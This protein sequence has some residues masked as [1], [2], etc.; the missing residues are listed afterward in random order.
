VVNPNFPT[1]ER[2]VAL[3]LD[4]LGMAGFR[5]YPNYHGYGLDAACFRELLACASERRVPLQV[6][7]R[8]ADERMHHP[9]LKV[10]AVDL[11][12]L[13]PQLED[14][15]AAAVI[16]LNLRQGEFAAAAEIAQAHERVFVEISHVEIM[17]GVGRLLDRVPEQQVLFGTHAPLLYPESAVLKLQE[18][19]LTDEQHQRIG[20]GNASQRVLSV[21]PCRET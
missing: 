16:L 4:E 19:D 2:D 3:Y 17:G 15:P 6:A 12:K 9:L 7:I 18:A 11:A 20:S 14:S 21:G 1:W 8:V 5:T 10:P 13:R